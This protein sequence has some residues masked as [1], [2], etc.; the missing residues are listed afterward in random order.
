MV[1]YIRNWR[2]PKEES[3]R[4]KDMLEEMAGNFPNMINY[5]PTDPQISINTKTR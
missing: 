2:L 1:H 5:K 3:K 4:D